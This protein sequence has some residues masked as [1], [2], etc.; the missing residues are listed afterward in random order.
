[1]FDAGNDRYW[2]CQFGGCGTGSTGGLNGRVSVEKILY[3]GGGGYWFGTPVNYSYNGT[4]P[5]NQQIT[6]GV[7]NLTLA[8]PTG[9]WKNGQYSLVIK[10]ERTDENNSVTGTDYGETWYQVKLWEVWADPVSVSD[11]G[12]SWTQS[13]STSDSILLFININNAGSWGYDEELTNGP[14]TVSVE[15]IQ[16]FASW[17]PT[18]LSSSVWSANNVTLTNSGSSWNA[19]YLSDPTEYLINISRTSGNWDSGYYNVVLNV[20]DSDTGWGYFNVISFYVSTQLVS[21]NG[22]SVWSVK[23]D[24]PVYYNVSSTEGYYVSWWG[25]DADYINTT[26]KSVTLNRW[27]MSS[28]GTTFYEYVRDLEGGDES[29]NVTPTDIS[30]STIIA[31]NNTGNSGQWPS[32]WYN[33]EIVLEDADGGTATGW[34]WFDA[35]PFVANAYTTVWEV[36]KNSPVTVNVQVQDPQDWST[37]IAGNYTVQSIVQQEYGWMGPATQTPVTNFTPTNFSQGGSEVG[38]CA[39]DCYSTE[40]YTNQTNCEA[41]STCAWYA[42]PWEDSYSY[43]YSSYSSATGAPITIY[44]PSGGWTSGYNNLV[45]TIANANNQTGEAWIGFNVVP[46]G[47]S[48]W[49]DQYTYSTDANVTLSVNIYDPINESRNATANV[50]RVFETSWDDCWTWPCPETEINFTPS[51]ITGEGTLTLVV[52]GG[53]WSSSYHYP[54]I[55]FV[56]S[57]DPTSTREGWAYFDARAMAVS[58]SISTEWWYQYQPDEDVVV[59]ISATDPIDYVTPKLINITRVF[60]TDWNNCEYSSTGAWQCD[61]TNM[62]F[63]PTQ[64][65]G[66]GNLTISAPATNWSSGYRNLEIEVVLASNPAATDSAYAYFDVVMVESST[67]TT[68]SASTTTTTT[69]STSTTST[70]SGDATTSSTTTSS[71]TTSSTTTTTSLSGGYSIQ[72]MPLLGGVF[73]PASILTKLGVKK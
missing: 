42:D 65:N 59:D 53:G 43:C 46:F 69:T 52:P 26:V 18:D 58:A 34:L 60:E 38:G 49:S 29:I 11:Y 24:G 13:Y 8:A 25:G 14:V 48:V 55:I 40:C 47:V 50:S 22:T 15:K 68:A 72:A 4:L 36:G 27:D 28:G 3:Y 9:G 63:S 21:S 45:M 7:G 16:D 66:S 5:S 56:D 32:G 39:G 62:T 73:V 31:I 30:G 35:R 57:T 2:T 71:T 41:D 19:W 17:P 70:V 1:M 6:N 67:T 44:P 54:T 23:G 20:N 33:G 64:I 12:Y 61:E 10:G 51:Q 37:E